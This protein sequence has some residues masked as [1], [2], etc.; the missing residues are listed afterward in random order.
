MLT[1]ASMRR[2]PRAGPWQSIQCWRARNAASMLIG[3]GSPTLFHCSPIVANGGSLEHF[4]TKHKQT[5]IIVSRRE[6]RLYLFPANT[7]KLAIGDLPSVALP[8][9]RRQHGAW[10][11]DV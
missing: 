11:R 5:W 6:V 10:T 4:R 3:Q 8:A 2:T 9:S 7:S 1:S